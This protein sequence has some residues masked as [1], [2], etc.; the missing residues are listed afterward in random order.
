MSE[1][2]TQANPQMFHRSSGFDT[3]QAELRAIEIA[4]KAAMAECFR[5]GFADAQA[6]R[7]YFEFSDRKGNAAYQRGYVKGCKGLAIKL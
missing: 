6:G 7:P 4:D 5:Q 2:R 3:R 1:N